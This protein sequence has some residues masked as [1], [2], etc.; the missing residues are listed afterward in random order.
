MFSNVFGYVCTPNQI[1]RQIL[2]DTTLPTTYVKTWVHYYFEPWFI[3]EDTGCRSGKS[4]SF[5][6]NEDGG[7][8]D[9]AY[10]RDPWRLE[11]SE[12][13]CYQ[14]HGNRQTRPYNEWCSAFKN[15]WQ[16]ASDTESFNLCENMLQWKNWVPNIYNVTKWFGFLG[17]RLSRP[18]V[19]L[20]P[21][22]NWEGTICK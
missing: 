5:R 18:R 6:G 13:H 17:L 19:Q 4:F 2:I 9:C 7:P 22:R 12:A 10:V 15:I 11:L 14:K 21:I 8:I 3:Q 16:Q 1:W 20:R